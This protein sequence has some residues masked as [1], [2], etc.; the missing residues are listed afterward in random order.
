MRGLL[1]ALVGAVAIAFV[2][3]AGDFIWATW[4]PRHRPLY[5]LTHGS[6][7]FLAI[8]FFL[9]VLAIRPLAGALAGAVL[10]A[11]AAG[12]F[13]LLA[14]SVGDSGIVVIWCGVWM[15]L[16]GV[17]AWLNRRLKALGRATARGLSAGVLSGLAFHGLVY[18][19]SGIWQPLDPEGWDYVW[20][21]AAWTLTVFPGL[22]ALLAYRQTR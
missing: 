22:A 20:H 11:L 14:P 17:D 9:G 5:G 19:L 18:G 7:L 21:L 13:D 16:G 15:A 12:S 3:T 2:S 6:L 1:T 4:I 8:G 10:G